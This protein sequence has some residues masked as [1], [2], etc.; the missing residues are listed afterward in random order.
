MAKVLNDFLYFVPKMAGGGFDTAPPKNHTGN[1]TSAGVAFSQAKACIA[2][3]T[4][5]WAMA[6]V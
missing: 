1:H 3:S 5:V 2:G 4:G 6:L